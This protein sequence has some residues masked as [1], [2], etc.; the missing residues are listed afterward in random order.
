[1]KVPKNG[2]SK[3]I[4][5]FVSLSEDSV[6]KAVKNKCNNNEKKGIKDT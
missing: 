4:N 5:T 1:M 2:L 3:H 6:S